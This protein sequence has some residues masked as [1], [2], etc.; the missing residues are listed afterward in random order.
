MSYSQ[1]VYDAVRSKIHGGDIG[2]AVRDV[3]RQMC[4]TSFLQQQLQSLAQEVA[5]EMMR[6]CVLFK[7]KLYPDGDMWCALYGD[8]LA[9]GVSGFGKSPQLALYAFDKAWHET[10]P[11]EPKP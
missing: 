2:Q 1:E 10:M 8:D 9:T 3:L 5:V 4:D 6:P 7:P 11:Q